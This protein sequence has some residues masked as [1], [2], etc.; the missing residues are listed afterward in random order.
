[1][2]LKGIKPEI[3][4]RSNEA[5]H[6]I[7]SGAADFT[8][9]R[10]GFDS[11]VIGRTMAEALSAHVGDYVTL[12]SA[13][14]RLTPYGMVPRSRRFRLT[15]IFDSGFSDYDSGMALT[16][17]LSAQNL[18]GVGD[19]ATVLEF[20]IQDPDHAAE[21]ARRVGEVAG[22]GFA[23]TTWENQ[24]QALFSALHL[25]KLIT[26]LFVGLITFVA[27]LNILGVLAMTVT[28]HASD[29]AVLVSLGTYRSQV[30][31]IFV[32]QGLAIGMAGTFTGLTAGYIV[33]W[34]AG[35]YRLFP[36]DPEVYSVPFIPF[37]ANAL[38]A[39]WIGAAALCISLA[40]TLI[41]AIAAS[42]VLPVD[43]LR[44]E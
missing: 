30:R 9:D 10:D 32:L 29:I 16:P 6:R 23:T 22:A 2:V 18:A 24:N 12:I 14:G 28:D 25:E 39:L 15:G 43:L 20:R 11:I 41:P 7:V 31:S 35:T 42:R 13:Q 5:L 19:V 1:V 36:L 8:P 44:Y 34:T 33:A 3:E 4:Q 37:H 21:V 38:D 40:A 17:L 27:G 26:A